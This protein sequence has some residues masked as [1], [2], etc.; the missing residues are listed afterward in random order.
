MEQF[1][2]NELPEDIYKNYK[3]VIE[4][5]KIDRIYYI[6]NEKDINLADDIEIDGYTMR[7]S[8]SLRMTLPVKKYFTILLELK[9]RENIK[10]PYWYFKIQTLDKLL[11]I[12]NKDDQ[13]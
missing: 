9:S 10:E 3:M 4:R 7:M 6:E 8:K 11:E 12:M 13:N 2:L 5:F 1:I